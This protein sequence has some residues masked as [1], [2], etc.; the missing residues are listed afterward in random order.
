MCAQFA[1]VEKHDE[2]LY[3]YMIEVEKNARLRVNNCSTTL[4]CALER[5]AKL[6]ITR[7]GVDESALREAYHDIAEPKRK[8]KW[9][10]YDMIEALTSEKIKRSLGLKNPPLPRLNNNN[11]RLLYQSGQYKS[12]NTYTALRDFGNAGSHDGKTR[13]DEAQLSF[14]N[15]RLCLASLHNFLIWFFHENQT[16]RFDADL[17]DIADYSITESLGESPDGKRTRCIHEYLGERQ[18]GTRGAV[19]CAILRQYRRG[20]VS[21]ELLTRNMDFRDAVTESDPDEAPRGLIRDVRLLD[22]DASEFSIVVYEF[23]RKPVRL[24][25]ALPLLTPEERRLICREIAACFR[26]LHGDAEPFYHRLLTHESVY[27]CDLGKEGAHKWRP[28][29]KFDFAKITTDDGSLTV[30]GDAMRAKRSVREKEVEKY[31][32]TDAWEQQDWA[33]ADCYA[34][35]V[36]FGDILCGE[37]RSREA[38]P[39]DLEA[40]GCSAAT[41]QM[42]DD[43]MRGAAG[44]DEAFAVLREG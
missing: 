10:L 5:I 21:E 36:L 12:V 13:Q 37:I 7:A 14:D 8:Y 28:Y 23:P 35:G 42:V 31:I 4:R 43:L 17:M 2:R 33:Y 1:F 3:Q 25:D 34:L 11:T 15:L 16:A 19:R 39:E 41:A 18:T 9:D 24:R 30:I 22:A 38:E 40:A 27:V 29:I 26:E 6:A 20:D 44:A 32:C